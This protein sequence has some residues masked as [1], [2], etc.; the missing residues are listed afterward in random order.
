MEILT[1]EILI[2][3]GI[4]PFDID[5]ESYFD[6]GGVKEHFPDFKIMGMFVKAI[7]R[8]KEIYYYGKSEHF[9]PLTDFDRR[10]LIGMKQSRK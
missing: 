2:G 10:L 8:G 1:D 3:V 9:E 6:V 5:G 7:T 4:E